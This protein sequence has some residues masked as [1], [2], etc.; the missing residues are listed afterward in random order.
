M[1][2]HVVLSDD[3]DTDAVC[4]NPIQCN[5]LGRWGCCLK[6]VVADGTLS[7]WFDCSFYM[8][9]YYVTQCPVILRSIFYDLELDLYIVQNIYFHEGILLSF[10]NISL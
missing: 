4:D 3:S 9:M 5:M 6:F 1:V 2:S 7:H 8:N 10:E